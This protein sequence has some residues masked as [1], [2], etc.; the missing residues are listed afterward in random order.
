MIA[1]CE[2]LA[3]VEVACRERG[4]DIEKLIAKAETPFHVPDTGREDYITSEEGK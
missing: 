4:M 2:M 1:Y 3:A